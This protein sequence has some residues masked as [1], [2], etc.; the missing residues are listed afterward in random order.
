MAEA[1]GALAAALAAADPLLQPQPPASVDRFEQDP[2][3]AL[4][5]FYQWSGLNAHEQLLRESAASTSSVAA[6]SGR[7]DADGSV[8]DDSM[9]RSTGAAA[10][11]RG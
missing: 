6:A 11:E 10:R 3:L 1:E 5:H 8:A 4:C 2:K 7:L 9:A